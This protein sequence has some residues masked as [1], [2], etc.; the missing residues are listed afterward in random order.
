[1]Y[2][3]TT[4]S[5]LIH[6]IVFSLQLNEQEDTITI[7]CRYWVV[8]TVALGTKTYLLLLNITLRQTHVTL[9][10]ARGIDSSLQNLLL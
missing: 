6:V 8:T 7:I 9:I 3:R 2:K 5:N 4:K 1:M 10:Y